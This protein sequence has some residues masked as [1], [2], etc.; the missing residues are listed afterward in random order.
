MLDSQTAQ[1]SEMDRLLTGQ[2]AAFLARPDVSAEERIDRLSRAVSLLVDK[3]A[4]FEEAIS[5]DF[6]YRSADLSAFADIG[7]SVNALR[8]ARK[9]VKSWMRPERR[10]TEFPLNLTGARSFVQYQ[11][12]GVV[13]IMAPWNF[14]I[15]MV[16][17]PLAGVFAAGNR[18]LAKPSEFTPRTSD[19][20]Q[21][22]VAKAFK[23]DEFAI[24]TGEADVG[25]A[26]S[27]L[28]FDHII[29]TG[30][31]AVGRHVMRAAADN[32]VPVTLELGGKSPVVVAPDADIKTAATRILHGK[33]FNAG[34]ICIA[35]D[36]VLL[37][38]G[39]EDEFADAAANATRD[40]FPEG[41]GK[42]GHYTAL[43]GERHH[44][45]IIAMMGDADK[46]GAEVLPLGTAS[47]GGT[48]HQHMIAPTLILGATSDMEV[49]QS[50]I[51]GPLLPIVN[52]DTLDGALAYVN[53]RDRPL[54]LY[55]FGKNR[56]ERKKVLA[57]TTSGGVTINDTIMHI[58]QDDLP[59]GGVGSSGMGHY[60]G[61]DGFKTF[62]HQKGVFQ[63]SP[64]DVLK[65][66]R[67]PYGKLFRAFVNSKIKK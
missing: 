38:K 1:G 6:G 57:Q 47:G 54:A 17:S 10:H 53:E 55:F 33:I 35:P 2:R 15:S 23:P 32:L 59:F 58:A 40:M 21:D 12:K 61:K 41:L 29:F 25:A 36:Y 18:A 52:Y 49:M 65:M 56:A 34:Q 44:K 26:F 46:K 42:S 8:H 43:L 28:P 62:S 27:G 66:V 5:R 60:H 11:P 39:K 63:Q 7:A 19:L 30:S 37:P 31:T 4:A 13:G 14:P 50:E 3:R 51:F 45:R 48:T 9:H 24:I 20:M 64:F 22:A 16:F 67:P